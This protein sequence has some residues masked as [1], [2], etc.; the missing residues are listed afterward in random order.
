[1]VDCNAAIV[2][3]SC[4]GLKLDHIVENHVLKTIDNGLDSGS[5]TF[6]I[7]QEHGCLTDRQSQLWF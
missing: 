7:Y 3:V 1:M 5:L 2:L 4:S 6:I